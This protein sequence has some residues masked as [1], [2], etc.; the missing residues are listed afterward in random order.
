LRRCEEKSEPQKALRL[1]QRTQEKKQRNRGGERSGNEAGI[2]SGVEREEGTERKKKEERSLKRNNV[3]I[4]IMALVLALMVWLSARQAHRGVSVSD[5]SLTGEANGKG[6]P[7]FELMDVRTGKAVRLSDYRGKAVL[8]NFWATWCPP[9]KEEIPWFIDLQKQ[10]ASQGL[11][12]L[13]VAL[14]DSGQKEIASFAEQ[15][16]M[17]YPVLL[18]NDAV[19]NQYG[20]VDALPTTFYIGRDGKI[21]K[22]VFGLVGPQQVEEYI[23]AALRTSTS[24]RATRFGD[25]SNLRIAALKALSPAVSQ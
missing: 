20:N 16:S 9:C 19:S 25:P 18:G 6:A 17:N 21:V 22:R 2:K 3:V 23:K 1:A 11:V 7:D 15:M 4:G 12:V 10:Y 5:G 8:L 24:A 14:D 13:G